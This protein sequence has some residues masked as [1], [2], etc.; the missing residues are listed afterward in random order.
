MNFKNLIIASFTLFLV[1]CGGGSSNSGAGGGDVAA[2]TRVVA[3]GDSFGTGFGIA[4][5]WPTRLQN[6]LGVTVV[7]NSVDGRETGEG[8]GLIESLISSE[9]P[10]HI[11]ILLGTND[12]L[13]GS[14]PEAVSN[15][16]AMVN[17]ANQNNV[18]AIVGTLAP[19][20]QSSA[21]NARAAEISN[22]IQGLS[23]ARIADI[24]ARLDASAIVD[25]IH[26]N[27]AGQQ[28]IAD[29]IQEQF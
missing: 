12:A 2:I 27:D 8:L 3:L 11:V 15:L 23:G 7:N 19:I 28:V 22:G 20:T 14:V 10:S 9:N 16:Q 4:T 18:I 6:A 25:G 24:R 13:R 5:P 26:P 21:L 1:A 17:I 29:V